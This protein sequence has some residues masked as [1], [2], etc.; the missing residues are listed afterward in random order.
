MYT[1]EL[2]APQAWHCPQCTS[3]ADSSCRSHAAQVDAG[4]DLKKDIAIDNV[5]YRGEIVVVPELE[6]AAWKMNDALC[7]ASRG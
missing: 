6:Q 3:A 1:K 2:N 7:S 5:L 4:Q